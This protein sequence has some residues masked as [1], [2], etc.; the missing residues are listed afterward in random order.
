MA[1]AVVF[2]KALIAA[3]ANAVALIQ[4]PLAAGNLTL[5]AG[6]AALDSQRRLLFTFGSNETGRILTVR[7]YND[8]GG[9]ICETIAGT[10]AGTVASK[11]DYL[12]VT[13]ISID[14]ASAGN[15]TVG[16]NSIG[17]TPWALF[18]NHLSP[19][20]LNIDLEILSGSGNASIEWTN[21][22]FTV[23]GQ[24]ATSIAYLTA[25]TPP[26]AQALTILDSKT[27]SAQGALSVP[28]RGWRLTINSG[29][30]TWK[31][32]GIASG[33]SGP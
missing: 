9:A 10:T 29:T 6:A 33:I 30:G 2:Q 22:D 14:A 25:M 7:G 23:N 28:I 8:S 18:N 21:D 12:T 19:P 11:F 13:Q 27:A 16:T 17:S 1:R 32:T 15:I 5:T 3:S 24:E 31:A 26:V 4:Q 20:N